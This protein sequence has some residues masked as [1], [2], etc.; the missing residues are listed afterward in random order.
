MSEL[1]KCHICKKDS[2]V[3]IKMDEELEAVRTSP[4][5]AI[6]MGV[7]VGDRIC[8]YPC[9]HELKDKHGIEKPGQVTEEFVLE[10]YE[11]MGYPVDTGG[12]QSQT[13]LAQERARDGYAEG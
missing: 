11:M 8:C 6:I 4:S 2:G 12:G 5:P 13:D 3:V 9:F 1:P 7:E 10:F